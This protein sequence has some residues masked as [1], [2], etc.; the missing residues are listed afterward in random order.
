[1]K[2]K[3]MKITE[4]LNK[5]KPQVKAISVRIE[6]DL[7]KRLSEKLTKQDKT[8]SAFIRAAAQSYL[9]EK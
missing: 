9:Q 2:S 1:M 8:I 6:A 7:W 5:E 4:I 3:N